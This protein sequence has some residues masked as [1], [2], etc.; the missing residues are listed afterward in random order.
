[1]ELGSEAGCL[2]YQVEEVDNNRNPRKDRDPGKASPARRRRSWSQLQLLGFSYDWE[3]ELAT[4]D[5]D[6][7]RW[8]QFIFLVLFDTWFD[9][10]QKRGR[11][12]AELPIPAEVMA[13]GETAVCTYQDE[14][15]LAFQSD[16]LVNWCPNLG[17]V[18]A[19]EEVI[20]GRSERGQ[21]PVNRIPLRQW[22]LRITDYADRLESGLDDLNWPV[23]IKKLQ[24]DWIG[25]S[26]GAEVDFFIDDAKSFDAWSKARN[27][28]GYPRKPGD[29]VLRIYTTRPDTL[30]GATYMVIAPEHSF[31][32][33]LTTVEQYDAVRAY[34]EQAANKSDLE[35]TE[36][37][38]SKTGVFTGAYA[39]NPVN[40]QQVPIWIAEYVLI[41]YGTGAIMAVPAHDTR[42]FE[43]AQQFDIPI[44]AVV[45]CARSVA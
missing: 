25:R 26:T 13:Q 34:C 45:C 23:G 7:F 5:V 39:I 3:R 2:G 17:T 14:H 20:D 9:H 31:V 37:A 18:L 35:R 44:V 19:N 1:M 43:F 28:S 32:D 33:R 29:D 24:K 12:I 10:E 22:M 38:K 16:A 11:A 27:E 42:D 36:L 30:F 21:H 4:T 6:Y 41:S 8:T 40:G 15:R